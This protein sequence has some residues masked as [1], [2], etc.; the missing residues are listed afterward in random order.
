MSASTRDRRWEKTGAGQHAA[1]R[2]AEL[3]GLGGD[4][5]MAVS[6]FGGR[7]RR[8]RRARKNKKTKKKKKKNLGQEGPTAMAF[9]SR[10]GPVRATVPC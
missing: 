4:E 1:Q 3:L 9:S 7:S 10:A 6:E 2:V 5:R 8:G